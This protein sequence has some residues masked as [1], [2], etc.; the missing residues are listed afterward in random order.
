MAARTD[1]ESGKE[2][3]ERKALLLRIPPALHADLRRWADAELRSLNAHIEHLL[4]EA[5]QRRKK[6]K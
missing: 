3:G 4:R 2:G 5:V 1:G 6:G